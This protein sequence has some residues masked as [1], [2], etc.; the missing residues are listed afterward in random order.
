MGSLRALAGLNGPM[1]RRM[2]GSGSMGRSM[3]RGF[4]WVPGGIRMWGS[5]GLGWRMGMGCIPG[6]MGISMRASLRRV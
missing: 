1:G 3:A 4:G 6:L 5:G 2:R